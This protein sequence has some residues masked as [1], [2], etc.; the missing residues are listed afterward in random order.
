MAGFNG[1]FV[2]KYLAGLRMALAIGA[3]AVVTS[4]AADAAPIRFVSPLGPEAFGATGTGHVEVIFDGV[5]DTLEI[6]AVF[7]GLSGTTTIAHIHCCTLVP[8]T[9]T[10]GVAVTPGTLPGFPVG[11]QAGTYSVL[12]DLS[13]TAIYTAAFRNNF[14][15]GT[16]AGAEAA[17]LAGL[18]GGTAYFNIHSTIFPGGEI[19]GFLQVPEPASL[20]LLG[21]GLVGL[22]VR[23]RTIG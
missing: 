17:L 12:L 4:S 7:S 3:L 21:A 5:A 19:R 11:V 18:L 8:G 16:A 15:G 23:R 10:V 2:R 20:L 1:R 13:N 22:A 6:D 9:G 14:G